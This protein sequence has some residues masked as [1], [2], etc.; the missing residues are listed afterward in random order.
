VGCDQALPV[1]AH[2]ATTNKKKCLYILDD[3]CFSQ[4][5]WRSGAG[6]VRAALAELYRELRGLFQPIMQFRDP[7]ASSSVSRCRFCT[8]FSNIAL[9]LS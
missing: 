9:T 6:A 8:G 1:K 7:S 5:T 3:S 2:S 4:A